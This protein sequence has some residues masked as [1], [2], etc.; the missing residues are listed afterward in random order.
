MRDIIT[1]TL[2]GI[3]ALFTV[4]AAVGIVRMPD[5]FTRLQTAT[6]ASTLGV[7]C[8]MLAAAVH[9]GDVASGARAV[10]ITGFLFVTA[11]VAA[12]AIGRAAYFDGVTLWD[13]TELDEWREHHERD[14]HRLRSRAG[15]PERD[16]Q[17][18]GTPIGTS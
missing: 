5:L 16:E 8:V 13:K 2:V 6:K 3:G 4:L 15:V 14:T 10:L 17:E 12:H 7:A 1:V 9:F 18:E 11:P